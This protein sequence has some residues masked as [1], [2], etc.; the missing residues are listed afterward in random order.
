MS[1]SAPGADPSRAYAQPATGRAGLADAIAGLSIAGLLLPEAVAYAGLAGLPPQSGVM[2]LF[3][4][5]LIYGVLGSSRFAIVSSTSSSAAVLLAALT[6]LAVPDL[7]PAERLALAA[8]LVIL[9]GLLFLIAAAARLGNLSSL[10]AKPVLRGFSLGLALT[11]V[12]K[13][14]PKLLGVSAHHDDVFRLTAGLI[15]DL[16]RWNWGSA[17]MGLTALVL[18]RLM[19]RWRA[20]PAGLLVI[21][22]GIAADL[23]GLGRAWHVPAVGPLALT[24]TLPQWPDLA[25]EQW[26]RVGQLAIPLALILYA[27]SY[28]SIRSFAIRHGDPIR[29]NRDLLALG[30]AN[31]LAGLLQAMPV[32]AGYSATSANEGA[33]ARSRAAGLIAG[34]V[35]ALAVLT[36]LPWLAHI[37]EPVLAAI[38]IHAVAHT[39]DPAGVLPYFRWRRDR[40]V[41]VLAFIAVLVLGVLDGLLAAIAGSL[42]MLLRRLSTGRVEW[43]GQLADS[44]DF[45]D[46]RRHPEALVPPGTLIARPDETLFFGNAEA[47]LTTVRERVLATPGVARLILSLEESP[48]LDATSLEALGDLAAWARAR[49]LVLS[50]ARVKDSVRHLLARF[51]SPDLPPTSY[52]AWSVDDAVRTAPPAPTAHAEPT[53]RPP[54]TPAA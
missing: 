39:L 30:G 19:S 36:L 35:I 38:V 13:Q 46:T 5:L 23:A 40:F 27:E 37:P 33:G 34:A 24:W 12:I 44:H 22:L 6:S 25:R 10:V 2:A 48:D 4:G 14:C 21:A 8:A 9:T 26:L 32:G 41:V 11:I 42:L 18:L 7:A 43:L 1:A 52:A 28:G 45:V 31:L 17:A 50:L 15:A 20:L 53:P 54:Q 51:D 49:G 3:A 16:P 47:V 29:A